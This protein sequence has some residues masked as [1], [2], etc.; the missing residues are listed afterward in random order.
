MDWLINV[1]FFFKRAGFFNAVKEVEGN[2]ADP[3]K[4]CC[5]VSKK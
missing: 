3:Y 1:P 4:Q 2:F 5:H